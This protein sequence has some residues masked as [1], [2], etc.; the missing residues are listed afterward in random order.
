MTL[1]DHNEAWK[2]QKIPA[3]GGPWQWIRRERTSHKGVCRGFGLCFTKEEKQS[4]SGPR[5]TPLPFPYVVW[6]TN[7]DQGQGGTSGTARELDSNPTS[8]R[9][10]LPWKYPWHAHHYVSQLRCQ[11]PRP[12]F[13]QKMPQRH[14]N[15][16]WVGEYSFSGI[17]RSDST[18][19]WEKKRAVRAP[20]TLQR[21]IMSYSKRLYSVLC[22]HS[23][24]DPLV[25][26]GDG[27]PTPSSRALT[28]RTRKKRVQRLNL[29][30]RRQCA[31]TTWP[32]L[33]GGV[34]EEPDP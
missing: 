6:S 4:G 30:G 11:H 8:H 20:F 18:A 29:R 17:K 9:A 25:V 3:C 5:K 26:R 28:P 21:Y 34:V 19:L 31:P 33:E 23:Y 12:T 7:R 1:S 2:G 27:A 10:V 22:E 32:T 15:S 13:P 14:K 16:G 24:D